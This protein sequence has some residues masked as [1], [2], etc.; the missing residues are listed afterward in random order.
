MTAAS[1]RRLLDYDAATGLFKWR[2]RAG[3]DPHTQMWNTKFAGRP[4]GGISVGGYHRISINGV[5][6]YSHHLAWLH[7]YGEWPA[8]DLD[9]RDTDK[10]HNAI[11]NLRL[12]TDAQNLSN[13]VAPAG[14]TSGYKGVSWNKRL[15]RWHAYIGK[16]G[17][18]LHLGF[19][20]SR[21][22][23]A[24]AYAEA[25]RKIHGDFARL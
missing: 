5:R 16:E 6:Y 8:E 12:A 7:V 1:V 24:V 10:A 21:D 19:F 3:D 15:R 23:A 18:R 22:E 14:N 9:H 2:T 25:A 4:A 11:A 17:R 20:P 13:R